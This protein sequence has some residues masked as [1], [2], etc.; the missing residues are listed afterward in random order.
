MIDLMRLFT[1]KG[2][3]FDLDGTL[4]DSEP[5]HLAAWQTLCRKYSLPVMTLEDRQHLGGMSIFNIC[6]LLCEQNG[7]SELD[8]VAMAHEKND[9]YRS[10]Y[11]K[12]VPLHPYIASLLQQ[13]HAKGLKTA[14]ATG[15]RLPETR[16]LLE[17]YLLLQ[18]TDAIVTSDQVKHSKP[19][20]DTYLICAERLGLAP[21]HCVVFEDTELGLQ[22]IKAAGMTAVKVSRDQ[23]ISDFINPPN[24][25]HHLF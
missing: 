12:E 1:F 11:L 20:P 9:L 25:H 5:A 6:K 21:E 16:Y 18:C 24:L 22:G 19:A 15:S 23:I 10:K 4:I 2:A 14:V 3:I 13:A 7:R 8:H 17:K